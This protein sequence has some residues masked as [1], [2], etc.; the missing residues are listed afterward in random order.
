MIKTE[1]QFLNITKLNMQSIEFSRF[2]I[3]PFFSMKLAKKLKNI[4]VLEKIE[5]NSDPVK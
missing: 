2:F 3:N 1:I 5:E 4:K